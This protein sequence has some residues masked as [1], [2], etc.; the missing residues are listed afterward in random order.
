V[1][2]EA[3]DGA[4]ARSTLAR[5]SGF[6][7]VDELV[8]SQG[9]VGFVDVHAIPSVLDALSQHIERRAVVAG[10]PVVRVGAADDAW[11][12]LSARLGVAASSDPLA[13]ATGIFTRARRGVVVV[14]EPVP[15]RWGGA[16]AKELATL[17]SSPD[18]PG[19]AL[20]IVLSEAPP[21]YR[22][23]TIA[24]DPGAS[25]EDVQLWWDAVARDA[26]RQTP[27][28]LDRIDA[29]E[30]W[31]SAARSTPADARFA[32]PARSAAAQILLTRLALSQRSWPIAEAAGL[33]SGA[34]L[35]E[36][37]AL[38]AVESDASGRI[39]CRAEAAS[40]SASAQ[41]CSAFGAASP[42]RS[43]L[44]GPRALRADSAHAGL[45][46]IAGA[47]AEARFV[48]ERLEAAASD[49]P[50][51]AAR[52]SE[53][54]AIAGDADQ[55]EAASVRALRAVTDAGARCDFWQR[56]ERTLDTL[57][58][59]DA[60][61]RLLRCADLALDV[62]DA[63]RAL[64]FAHAAAARGGESYE[65]MLV[66]GRAT[67]VRGDLTTA[68]IALGKAMELAPVP[69]MRARAAVEIAEVRY[70]AG[71][72]EDA[73]KH[74]A[75]ALADGADLE[76]RLLARNV[77]GKLLLASAAW[78]D[79]EQHF[80]ADACEA[81]CG[82]DHVGE[83]RARLNRAIALLSS[84]R[85]DEARAMLLG[86]LED[87]ERRTNLRAVAYALSNLATIATLR[88]DYPEALSLSVRAI[89]VLRRMGEKIMLARLITNLAE[90]RLRIGL[91]AEAEQALLFGRQAC[92]PGM[93]GA[94][95][96]SFALVAAGIHLARG[97]TAEANVELA[98]AIAG[99]GRAGMGSKLGECYR[100]EARVA[101][102]DGDLVRAEHAIGKAQQEATA[103]Y[104]RAEIAVLLA[105]RARAAGEDFTDAALEALDLAREVA[106]GEFA[107][108]AHLLL[109]LAAAA[110][111]D[112]RAAVMHLDAAVSFRNQ[113][114]DVLPEELR[115]RFLGRR[116][117]AELARIEV[118]MVRAR[119]AALRDPGTESASPVAFVNADLRWG[120]AGQA[121][122]CP[123]TPGAARSD[124][125][126]IPAAG[127][128][129]IVGDDPA[130]IALANAIRKVGQSDATVLV[131]GESGTGKELVA[132]AIHAA[133]TRRAGPMVKVN[134]SA[135]VETLLL[136]ELFGHEKGSFTGAAAR[137]RG[138][139]ELAEGGTIFLD[140]IGDISPRT[141]VALLRVLQDRSYE[142]VG[143]VT[144]LRA[145]VRI[146]CAT[147]RDLRAMVARGEFREDLFYRLRG[148][149][150][151][152][153]ALRQRIGD[154][155]PIAAAILAGIAAERGAPVKSLS[156][157]ALEGLGR[158]TWP[159]N[160]RELENAL[161]AAA[162]FTDGDT[163]ELEDF[164]SNVDGLRS[165]EL[166]SRTL[167][168]EEVSP[169]TRNASGGPVS[170]GALIRERG[171]GLESQRLALG[172]AAPR[173]GEGDQDR[174]PVSTPT[175]VAYAHIRG[176]VSLFDMKRQIERDCIERALAESQGN[177]T[178]AAAL[179][180]MKRPR[181]SQ[182]VK[183]YGLGS[184]SE[185]S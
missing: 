10:R 29:L 129:P 8:R 57:P 18:A 119:E 43:A 31:W 66:L 120:L 16:V 74:A 115:R 86:V 3:D 98:S 81:A 28:R 54:Y 168:P 95:V 154:V 153:P 47:E 164:T 92:N 22:T 25:A 101:L 127:M 118:E 13:V 139:F 61:P 174:E 158:H 73:R 161:R 51:A 26:A 177:I 60:I 7:E 97:R 166:C 64:G 56:W 136:S 151:E 167:H 23:R 156:A 103:S 169:G 37:I 130:M 185:E 140:E 24:V 77:A 113:V 108:E 87:G 89:D 85:Y 112:A 19:Q 147:H 137:R 96:T 157:R 35:D 143:G 50:W 175:E 109:Y 33:G 122:L 32:P 93:P 5:V 116:D 181:L 145:N 42:A 83:L 82:G 184:G 179:L 138:R 39:A 114:A 165:L 78:S 163:I 134:C 111:N 84:G 117:L 178:R 52:A 41:A 34:A 88:H 149:V 53:L 126:R 106:D 4:D 132:E 49:D 6:H 40:P 80:A 159:G 131:C 11:R 94:A 48:A 180:G 141:Q 148:L 38:G 182:L 160:V 146:I 162:L 72:L 104:D 69:S 176:G 128:R 105:M 20:F 135:L 107:R 15:T 27:S 144:P 99:A 171:S 9:A 75:S 152:V 79:A 62:G 155:A 124:V 183:Q 12:D 58:G 170:V 76:T 133:S 121:R 1:Q 91:T 102:E 70:I 44:R 142:R 2:V 90:L 45:A 100:L 123:Q 63:D 30:G 68:A 17:A 14:F 67:T 150:L 71:D 65:S 21:A 46:P 55:A 125:S 110:R 59:G 36:L 173:R 172:A